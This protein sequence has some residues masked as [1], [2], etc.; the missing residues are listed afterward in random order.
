MGRLLTQLGKSKV[1]LSFIIGIGL[2]V[3]YLNYSGMDQPVVEQ[4]T[5]QREDSLESFNTFSLDFS[6][7][8]DKR[9]KGL[10][11]CGENPVDP[12]ITGEIK[13]PFAPF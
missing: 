2:V 12:G 1:I 6:I 5:I 9:Y 4:S 7:F 10:E 8:D 13:N 11:L 3:G